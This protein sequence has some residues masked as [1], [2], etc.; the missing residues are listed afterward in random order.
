MEH[1]F[2]TKAVLSFK[3]IGIGRSPD[4]RAKLVVQDSLN[5]PELLKYGIYSSHSIPLSFGSLVNVLA[6]GFVFFFSCI[7]PSI[8]QTFNSC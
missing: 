7:D 6:N 4:I 5:Y 1:P 8:C 3:S 2:L